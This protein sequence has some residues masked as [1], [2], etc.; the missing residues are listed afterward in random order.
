MNQNS[1]P[2]KLWAIIY[3]LLM[4]YA[5]SIAVMMLAQMIFGND[6]A[7]YVLCQIVAD[8]VTIPVMFFSFYRPDQMG[9][10]YAA[11]DTFFQSGRIS[12]DT[13]KKGRLWLNIVLIPVISLLIGIGL[14]NLILMSPLAELSAGYQE[15]VENFYGGSFVLEIIGS[16]ILTPILEE[17]VYRGVIFARLKRFMGFV[18][19]MLLGAFLFAFMHFNLV[20]FVYAFL[21]GL[22]L[23]V[24]MEKTAHVYGA[25]LG[26][27]IINTLAVIRTETGFLDFMLDKSGLAWGL[28][29]LCLLAGV[30][31]LYFYV[32][33]DG[34]K[35]V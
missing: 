14:N 7:H 27:M 26:H 24:F 25:I 33:L 23:I 16:A 31:G 35:N 9:A 10:S 22:V 21:I 4:Y 15:A 19:A 30:V 12:A 32:R 29:V 28:S 13:K 18:P 1:F 11:L 34:T 17:L 6:S 5:V 20:Q 2:M 8:C 3:P